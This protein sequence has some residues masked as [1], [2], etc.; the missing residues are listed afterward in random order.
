MGVGLQQGGVGVGAGIAAQ[1][2]SLS[3]WW[4]GE[5]PDPVMQWL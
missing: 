3:T 4:G 1:Q 2:A 5:A